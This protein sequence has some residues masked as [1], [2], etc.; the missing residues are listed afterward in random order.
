M[1]GIAR[2][3]EEKSTEGNHLPGLVEVLYKRCERRQFVRK[4][5]SLLHEVDTA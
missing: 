4:E 5:S 3:R 1:D 2:N